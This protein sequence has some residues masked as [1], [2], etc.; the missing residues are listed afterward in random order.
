MRPPSVLGDVIVPFIYF[1]ISL[2]SINQIIRISPSARI[3]RFH[4]EEPG[5]IPGFGNQLFALFHY[6]ALSILG[7][8]NTSSNGCF[9]LA[10]VRNELKGTRY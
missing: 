5:S 9:F 4:R 1:C 6:I 7:A 3:S 8:T 2:L 10:T